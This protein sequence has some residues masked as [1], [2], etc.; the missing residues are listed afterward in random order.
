MLMYVGTTMFYN[1][2]LGITDFNFAENEAEEG[3]DLSY[4]L[5]SVRSFEFLDCEYTVVSEDGQEI[6]S[7]STILTNIVDGTFTINETLNKTTDDSSKKPKEVQIKIFTEKFDPNL[8]NADGTTSQNTFF[9]Q[10]FQVE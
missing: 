6:A 10:K 2:G 1:T 4:M 5:R 7:G 8:K 9:E 3:Y